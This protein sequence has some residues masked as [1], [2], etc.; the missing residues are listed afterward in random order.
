MAGY[1]L[2]SPNHDPYPNMV[3][4][5]LP[6]KSFQKNAFPQSNGQMLQCNRHETCGGPR[7][8]YDRMDNHDEFL[9]SH[10]PPGR[11]ASHRRN[12]HAQAKGADNLD[13]MLF[14]IGRE[15]QTIDAF[16][17]RSHYQRGIQFIDEDVRYTEPGCLRR[18][19]NEVLEVLFPKYRSER[20]VKA[21]YPIQSPE[22]SRGSFDSNGSFERARQY[23]RDTSDRASE[24]HD[25]LKALVHDRALHQTQARDVSVPSTPLE[26]ERLAE[27]RR[28]LQLQIEQHQA[29][30][31]NHMVAM[32]TQ[33]QY[34]MPPMNTGLVQDGMV[35]GMMNH[36]QLNK[37]FA[38]STQEK[39][40][41]AMPKIN[42]MQGDSMST[43][44]RSSLPKHVYHQ[45][46]LQDQRDPSEYT[47]PRIKIRS[48]SSVNLPR[49]SP[50]R[51]NPPMAVK[52]ANGTKIIFP[53]HHQQSDASTMQAS[54][55]QSIQESV[56]HAMRKSDAARIQLKSSKK[57]WNQASKIR[58]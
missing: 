4:S 54:T 12:M 40:S 55:I 43:M 10:H 53:E 7:Y 16:P 45:Q 47:P 36:Q 23:M 52:V 30:M 21:S 6:P 14:H 28:M 31:T 11:Y 57:L 49:G 35:N 24:L 18:S 8:E 1:N 20:P 32:Q 42:E 38:P 17:R 3:R 15:Y 41:M 50:P 34:Q 26:D 48:Q 22:E 33:Q 19:F 29:A 58:A 2:H 25:Q 39:M 51:G 27:S 13:E 5:S 44:Q 46:Q 9:Y 37:M 56:D